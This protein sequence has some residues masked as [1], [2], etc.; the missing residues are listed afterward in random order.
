MMSVSEPYWLMLSSADFLGVQA[1]LIAGIYITRKINEISTL[2][3]VK[4]NQKKN[5]WSAIFAFEVSA[6]VGLAF[7][8]TVRMCEFIIITRKIILFEGI[9][10]HN[11]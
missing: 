10:L 11:M 2:E 4:K 7:D 3:C 5:L 9:L 8:V 6:I 1:F